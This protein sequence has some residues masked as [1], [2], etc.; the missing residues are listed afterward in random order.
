MEAPRMCPERSW[1][2]QEVEVLTDDEVKRLIEGHECE[3]V[4]MSKGITADWLKS[5][6]IYP[7]DTPDNE[8]SVRIVGGSDSGWMS[9]SDDNKDGDEICDLV[10]SLQGG[11]ANVFIETWSIPGQMTTA[12]IE[13]GRRQTREEV[14]DLCRALKAWAVKYPSS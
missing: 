13:L 12:V 7:G 8:F 9:S 6:G 5:V 1:H 4:V 10:V 3:G 2:R 11:E 14:L